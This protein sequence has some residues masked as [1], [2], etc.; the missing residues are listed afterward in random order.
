[1]KKI[2]LVL[3]ILFAAALSY[4]L[5]QYFRPS[6]SIKNVEPD[7]FISAR[8]L[9]RKLVDGQLTMEQ[10][11]NTVFMIEGAITSLEKANTTTVL[12]DSSVRCELDSNVRL[13]QEKGKIRIKGLLGGYDEFFDE[14]LMIK[15]EVE[16]IG[17]SKE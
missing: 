4:A 1:M 10:L 2:L 12:I 7:L 3:S 16:E 11:G 14:V 13:N 6:V 5:Y 9:K 15:C 8:D 17:Q